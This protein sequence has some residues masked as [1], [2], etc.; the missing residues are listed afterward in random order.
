MSLSVSCLILSGGADAAVVSCSLRRC[1]AARG[2]AAACSRAPAG[3]PARASAL[4]GPSPRKLRGISSAKHFL[5]HPS[6]SS[7][8][9]TSKQG[10]C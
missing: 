3:H 7:K 2:P 6:V 9:K 8:D 10:F 1:S 4:P 5:R